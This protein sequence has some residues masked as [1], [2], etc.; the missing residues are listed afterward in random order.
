VYGSGGA[1][2]ATTEPI[3]PSELADIGWHTFIL[4]TNEYADGPNRQ[5]AARGWGRKLSP[6]ANVRSP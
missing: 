1:E 3:G 5:R 2:G 4:Y 6:A